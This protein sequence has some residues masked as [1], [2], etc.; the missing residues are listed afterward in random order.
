[1]GALQRWKAAAIGSHSKDARKVL[2]SAAAAAA[3]AATTSKH[4][5]TATTTT[6]DNNTSRDDKHSTS[7]SKLVAQ[8]LAALQA[9]SLHTRARGTADV[10]SSS[11]DDAER[12]KKAVTGVTVHVLRA[13]GTHEQY[14]QQ[15]LIDVLK[16]IEHSGGAAAA[17]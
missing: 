15:Q 13:D 2:Q 17:T 12:Y 9:T 1:M 10:D 7:E 11:S 3:A 5:T 6:A 16:S 8:V 14:T 4:T